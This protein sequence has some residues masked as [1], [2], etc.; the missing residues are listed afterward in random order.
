MAAAGPL[1]AAVIGLGAMGQNHIRILRALSSVDLVAVADINVDALADATN[2]S[3]LRGY[4]DS[5]SLFSN[6]EIDVVTVCVPTSMHH[7]VVLQAIDAGVHVLVEKPIAGT[8]QEAQAMMA[9]SRRKNIRL[10]VGH[11]E[12]FNP[13]LIELRRR[14]SQAG[15]V[16]HVTARRIG[17]F[18]DR[19]RDVGVV[20]DLASHDIDAMRFLFSSPVRS[21]YAQTAQ[22]IHSKHEDMVHGIIRFDDGVIGTLDV[23]WLS[24]MKIRELA[25]TGSNGTFVANY[26][27]QDLWFYENG[28]A[29]SQWSSLATLKGIGEGDVTK[30]SFIRKEPLRAE[31]EAFVDFVLHGGPNPASA[32]DG[33]ETLSIAIE[34]IESARDNA[35]VQHRS[36]VERIELNEREQPRESLQ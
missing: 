15:I 34:L 10:M 17:P 30:Y 1:R 13:A 19:I 31:V 23:N 6:E 25:V 2:G 29:D 22:R 8:V 9:A 26:L 35:P 20:T 27:S 28:K 5:M 24:P 36:P 14:L 3:P 21:L 7:D 4:A 12:R 18:P 32:E 11:I 16:Y 33:T